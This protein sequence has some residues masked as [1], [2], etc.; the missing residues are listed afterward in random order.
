MGAADAE[1]INTIF[2]AA[3]S[4]KGGSGTFG[5]NSVASFTHVMETLLDEMRDGKR[6]VTQE[7]VDILLSSVDVLREML[8][9][10]RDD[11][12]LNHDA[13]AVSLF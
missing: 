8:Q 5:L 7:G 10:L 1:T 3:H 11:Q 13:I 12:P 6:E 2:R 9:S 4:I